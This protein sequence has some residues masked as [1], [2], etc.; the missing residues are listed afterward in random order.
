MLTVDLSVKGDQGLQIPSGQMD[1]PDGFQNMERSVAVVDSF[2][3]HI[4]CAQFTT[5]V[6]VTFVGT[7]ICKR[8]KYKLSCNCFCL[9]PGT[10]V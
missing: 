5:C 10:L 8:V 3:V 9:S 7:L 4:M 6:P 2:N 1:K